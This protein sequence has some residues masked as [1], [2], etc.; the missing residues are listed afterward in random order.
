[1]LNYEESEDEPAPLEMTPAQPQ[2]FQDAEI[3]DAIRS[4][5]LSDYRRKKQRLPRQ[6]GLYFGAALL[7]GETEPGYSEDLEVWLGERLLDA[8]LRVG[9]NLI[10][11]QKLAE[12]SGPLLVF[13]DF[14]RGNVHLLHLLQQ[15][16]DQDSYFLLI[17]RDTARRHWGDGL[18]ALKLFRTVKNT[19]DVRFTYSGI[20][21]FY[22][23]LAFERL[24]ETAMREL[25]RWLRRW[26]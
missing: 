23:S 11:T 10:P 3:L 21:W 24:D 13:M 9:L 14:Y 22:R 25:E 4:E 8:G 12:Y 1:M 16:E 17:G 6:I 5:A 18:D 26:F 15:R 7:P 19:A 20:P 2:E